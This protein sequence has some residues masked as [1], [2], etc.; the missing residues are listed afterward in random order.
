MNNLNFDEF[1]HADFD[2]WKKSVMKEL[3]EKSFDSI[4]WNNPNGFQL[5]AYFA[6]TQIHAEIAKPDTWSHLSGSFRKISSGA[7]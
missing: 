4:Q 7:K 1:P 3:G 6:G 5:E 2:Q